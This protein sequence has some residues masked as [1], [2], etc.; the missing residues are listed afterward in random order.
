M[1]IKKVKKEDVDKLRSFLYF[2]KYKEEV[3]NRF[4][5]NNPPH[6][7]VKGSR[8]YE[9]FVEMLKDKKRLMEKEHEL[10]EKTYGKIQ[11]VE[12]EEE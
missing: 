9:M 12:R 4:V 2:K 3:F 11:I 10:M 7:M 1:K 8:V 6:L 5:Q